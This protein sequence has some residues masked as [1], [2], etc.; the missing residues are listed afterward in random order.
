[1]KIGRAVFVTAVVFTLSGCASSSPEDPRLPRLAKKQTCSAK[2]CTL[3]VQLL[4]AP[5]LTDGDELELALDL[6]ADKDREVTIDWKIKSWLPLE[7]REDGVRFK[8]ET[9]NGGQFHSPAVLDDND[10]PVQKGSK[11]RWIDRNNDGKLYKYTIKLYPKGSDSP[12]ISDPTIKN[13]G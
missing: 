3:E 12:F 4:G 6:G 7:F 11:F 5:Y 1:M 8:A 9:P 13:Q 2:K 10:Q